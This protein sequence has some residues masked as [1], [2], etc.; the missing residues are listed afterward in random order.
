[1]SSCSV[2]FIDDSV[3]FRG[4]Y[5]P[6]WKYIFISAYLPVA[7][8]CCAF[9][10]LV[11]AGYI[12]M[13]SRS[14]TAKHPESAVC[15][16]VF[17]HMASCIWKEKKW[18]QGWRNKRDRCLLVCDNKLENPGFAVLMLCS[19]K[20]HRI[21]WT[22]V[23]GCT[24]SVSDGHRMIEY[25]PG[26]GGVKEAFGWLIFTKIKWSNASRWSVWSLLLKRS[27]IFTNLDSPPPR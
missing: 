27:Y 8:N 18:R 23:R 26:K 3:G 16:S 4:I 20:W 24:P 22:Y 12:C 13:G 11:R 14:A 19:T 10:S 21:M 15:T 5:C 2:I 7:T 1:M 25:T 17:L 6:K 9:I